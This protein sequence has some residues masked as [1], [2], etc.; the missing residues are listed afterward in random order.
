MT[1][2]TNGMHVALTIDSDTPPYSVLLVR[3]PVRIDTVD[4]IA[5]EYMRK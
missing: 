5:P 3:G 2:L 4:G 1:A